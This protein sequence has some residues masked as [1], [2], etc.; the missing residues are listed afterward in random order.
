MALEHIAGYSLRRGLGSGSVG[1]VWLVRDLGSGRHA[2]LKRLP[3]ASV[4]AAEEF[5]RD[6]ALARGVDHSHVSRLI[7]VRQTEREWLL[8]SQYVAAGT[9]TS[10]LERRGPLS[11]GELVTLI[12]PLAQALGALHRAGLTHGHLGAGDVMFDADGRP[13]LTDA[14]LRLLTSADGASGG[15]VPA[16]TGTSEDTWSGSEGGS[17][18]TTPMR[19]QAGPA[20]DLAALA[21]L[22]E[23]AGGD[24]QIFSPALFAGDGQQV[25]QR[26]LALTAPEPINPGFGDEARASASD[27]RPEASAG[28]GRS[29]HSKSASGG[30]SPARRRRSRSGGSNRSHGP[31]AQ[32]LEG[33]ASLSGEP[34][35]QRREPGSADNAGGLPSFTPVVAASGPTV[36]NPGPTSRRRTTRLGGRTSTARGQAHGEGATR[37]RGSAQTGGRAAKSRG[38]AKRGGRTSNPRGPA[39]RARG[40]VPRSQVRRWSA[41][42]V[43]G[44]LAMGGLAAFVMLEIGLVTLGVLGGPVHGPAAAADRRDRA[45]ELAP[46][47]GSTSAPASAPAPA[48]SPSPTLARSATLTPTLIPTLTPTPGSRSTPGSSP[49]DGVTSGV[50]EPGSTAS[51]SAPSVSTVEEAGRWLRILQALDVRRSQ[52]FSSLDPAGLDAIYVPGSSPWRADRSLLASYRD[53]WVRIDGL[54]LRIDQLAVERPGVGTVVLRVVDRLVAGTAVD[55]AGRRTPLP[56]GTSTTR[57]ITLTGEG[58]AWRISGIVAV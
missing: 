52:A 2:V 12:S 7:E 17:A 33:R 54:R 45:P 14:G 43:Y 3:A 13:V 8:F 25:G 11:L 21:A 20:E 41:R 38:W 23:E 35:V 40:R 58:D 50:G 42:S 47:P 57:R 55:K 4:P 19:Q 22:A 51:A 46:A 6:L 18:S 44:L 27:P 39:R 31:G 5:R 48:S 32:A 16:S 34:G 28:S 56:A 36:L 37:A 24:P 53:R 10:L 29:A 30:T 1:A 15:P 26:V 49:S 9:L